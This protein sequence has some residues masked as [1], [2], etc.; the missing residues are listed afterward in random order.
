MK[1]EYVLPDL[2]ATMTAD[3]LFAG[4]SQPSATKPVGRKP[5]SFFSRWISAAPARGTQV[6][7][8]PAPSLALDD[9]WVGGWYARTRLLQA[10]TLARF[11]ER[12]PAAGGSTSGT[13]E[14]GA[15]VLRVDVVTQMK[16][17]S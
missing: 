10:A 17:F 4:N 3:A 6:A 7:G 14:G 16:D 12:K 1:R 13:A 11:A 2:L 9:D 5:S 15:P 8:S